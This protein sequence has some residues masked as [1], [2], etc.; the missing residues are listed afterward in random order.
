MDGLGEGVATREGDSGW[1]RVY[2][3][4]EKELDSWLLELFLLRSMTLP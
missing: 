2:L 1:E 3:E 4:E